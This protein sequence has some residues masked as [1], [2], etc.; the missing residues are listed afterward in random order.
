MVDKPLT[1]KQLRRLARQER[2]THAAQQVERA[3]RRRV[4]LI[5]GVGIV[6]MAAVA[7]TVWNTVRPQSAAITAGLVGPARPPILEYA[8]QSRDHILPGQPHPPY[9]SNPPTSGWHF[10][11]PA[12]W[13]FYNEELPDELVVHNLE[14]GGIW[15]SYRSADDT[16]LIN[17]LMTLS[18]R[19]RSKVIITLRTKDDTR[20]A[21]AAWD[22]LMKLDHFDEAVIVDFIRQF[23]DRGPEFVPD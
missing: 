2:R 16:A 4:G 17:Q 3:R 13:G 6:A 21:V 18:R 8:Q 22:H 11:V 1:R 5:G 15:I 20:L 14:H 12:D 10:P 9:S 19:Y 23:R 7:W